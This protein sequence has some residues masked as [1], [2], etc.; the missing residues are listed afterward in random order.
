MIANNS[1][2]SDA[3]PAQLQTSRSGLFGRS[4]RRQ[5]VVKFIAFHQTLGVQH[6]ADSHNVMRKDDPIGS[7]DRQCDLA[8][9]GSWAKN[10]CDLGVTVSVKPM[11]SNN[12]RSWPNVILGLD[13]VAALSSNSFVSSILDTCHSPNRSRMKLVTDR[14]AKNP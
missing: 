2:C 8:P 5:E 11:F 1:A 3:T 6:D 9:D 14:D 4:R 7:I 13:T 10:T 12:W